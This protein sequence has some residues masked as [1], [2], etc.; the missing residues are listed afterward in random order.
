[1][2]VDLINEYLQ[3]AA[4]MIGQR[5]QAEIDYDNAVLEFL[6]SGGDIKAAVRA[7]NQKYPKDALEPGQDQWQDMA[8]RYEYIAEHKRILKK[9]DM[10][11]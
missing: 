10:K 3:S 2:H 4:E 7:A 6:E 1:M 5:S 11:G 8:E 9:L